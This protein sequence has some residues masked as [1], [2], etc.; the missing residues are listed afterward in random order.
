MKKRTKWLMITMTAAAMLLGTSFTAMAVNSGSSWKQEGDERYYTDSRGNKV[1]D[2]W[3]SIGGKKYRFDLD[4]SMLYG[5]HYEDDHIYYLGDKNDGS[6]K[7]GWLCLS[8]NRFNIPDE[9]DISET[10]SPGNGAECFYFLPNGKA[11]KA[12]DGEEYAMKAFNGRKYYFDTNGIMQTG[13]A[14]VAPKADNDTTGISK[15]RYFGNQDDGMMN[16]GWVFLDKHPSD[17]DDASDITKSQNQK[18]VNGE[19]RWYYFDSNG[20]PKYLKNNARNLSEATARISGDSYFFD[21]YGCIK[22]GLIR[23]NLNN[24]LRI[25][26]Y[27]NDDGKMQTGRIDA[28]KEKDGNTGSYYFTSSG[29]NRG[30]GFTGEKDHYLYSSGKL[31]AAEPGKDFEVFNVNQK[32]YL[33][34]ET[35]KAQTTDQFYKVGG[36]YAYEYA[37]GKI[38]RVNDNKERRYEIFSWGSLPVISYTDTYNLK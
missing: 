21:E 30:S 8:Y 10:K 5:W 25:C 23:F 31:V 22:N 7:T 32:A 26:A 16:K 1:T 24:G 17:S 6:M 29:D 14:A 4:G 37:G 35:G 15:F 12:E 33:V 36:K 18:P 27:F 3:F 9:G 28:L 38:Y 11:V 19:G 34:S 13:W 2:Q 20:I